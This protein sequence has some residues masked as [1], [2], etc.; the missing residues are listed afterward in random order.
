LGKRVNPSV[1]LFL[2]TLAVADDFFS[3]LVIAVF[4]HS[5]LHLTSAIYTLGAATIGFLLPYRLQFIK[6]LSPVATFVIIPIYIWINLLSH[7][8]FAS[9]GISLGIALVIARVLG[10]V[11]GISLAAW[12]LTRL[13]KLQLPESLDLREII[14]VGL[15][16]GMGMTV[17]LVIAQITLIVS[18]QLNQVRVALF[19][20]A[21]ISGTLGTLWLSQSTKSTD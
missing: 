7:L 17:S 5:K 1:R 4:F 19:I 13:T 9:S 6:Y 21:I 18:S 11:L 10:K 20:A 16:A 2:L 8:H 12:L 14:G 15:L 3:L